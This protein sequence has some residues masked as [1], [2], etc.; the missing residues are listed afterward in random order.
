MKRLILAICAS[1]ALSACNLGGGGTVHSA[2]SVAASV[3][4]TAGAPKPNLQGTAIDEKALTL[5]AKFVD[6]S[7]QSISAMVAAGVITPG[8]PKALA[9]ANGLDKARNAV[10]AAAAARNAGNA[11]TYAEALDEAEIA[12][13]L[14]KAAMN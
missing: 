6:V 4:D 12:I 13:A 11:A 14:I 7:A 9:L 2:A 1:L 8:S 3:A 10:N 5:A